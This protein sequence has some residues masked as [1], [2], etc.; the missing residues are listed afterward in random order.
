MVIDWRETTLGEV[1]L[2]QRGFDLPAKER[3]S[4]KIPIVSSSGISGSHSEVGVRGP[5]V[6][7]GRYGTIG[8]VFLVKEDF[9]PL[10]T[11]LW[12]KDFHGNDPQFISYLLRTIDF[13]SCSDK[14]SVPGVNRN[15]LHRIP[16]FCPPLPQQ[17]TIGRILGA[18]DDKIELNRKMNRTLEAMAKALFQS[19]FIDF[20]PVRAKLDGQNPMGMDPATAALFPNSFMDSE[21]G[22]IPN[23]WEVKSIS[24]VTFHVTKGDTPRT[25]ALQAAPV[26]DR[27]VT[28]LRVNSITDDGEVL[29]DKVEKIPESIH[30]GKS[31]RS[32]LKENDILYTNAG[33]IGRV[34]LVQKDLL[35][36]NTK[37]GDGDCSARP[38]ESFPVITVYANAATRIS[39]Q[40]PL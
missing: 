6:V 16:V 14:S 17:K 33:T 39:D 29:M 3:R 19:W 20:D 21:L 36:A 32:I 31:K 15:D 25:E 2:L 22:P 8:Q 11:T 30:F 10:N 1:A 18:L 28:M 27:M 7:T 12:V 4:G 37:S 40:S 26:N 13:H 9:W 38:H 34:V 35:P 5:G 24:D 23:G